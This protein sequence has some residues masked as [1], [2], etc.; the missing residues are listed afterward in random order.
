MKESTKRK[1]SIALRRYHECCRGGGCGKRRGKKKKKRRVALTRVKSK[2][3]KGKI[4][5]SRAASKGQ[6]TAARLLKDLEKRAS[7]YD[8]KYTSTFAAKDGR[9]ERR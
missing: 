1:I 6:Q 9:W 7:E 8:K 2:R 3:K 4:R 5:M